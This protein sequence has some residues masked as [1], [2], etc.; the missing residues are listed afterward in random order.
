MDLGAQGAGPYKAH[1]WGWDQMSS[2]SV[3]KKGW[4]QSKNKPML[5]KMLTEAN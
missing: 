3:L 1:L 5:L 4:A 2:P